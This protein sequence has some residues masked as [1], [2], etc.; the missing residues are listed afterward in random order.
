MNETAPDR[1]G[2]RAG[3][4][5]VPAAAQGDPPL[6]RRTLGAGREGGPGRD[7]RRPRDAR[8]RDR[9]RRAPRREAAGRHD[10]DGRPG[11]ATPLVRLHHVPHAGRQGVRGLLHAAAQVR[12]PDALQYAPVHQGQSAWQLYHGPGATTAV[13]FQPGADAAAARGAGVAGRGVPGGRRSSGHGGPLAREPR[14]GYIALRAFLL[15]DTPGPIALR[16]RLPRPNVVPFDFTTIAVEAPVIPR[17]WSAG[18]RCPRRS[19]R[20]THRPRRCLPR[21]A[22]PHAGR[23]RGRRAWWSC[24]ASRS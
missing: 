2:G 22:R 3:C 8:V 17:A 19:R 13:E 15:P 4:V 11:H 24:T 21:G 12:L 1:A 5:A 6:L 14:A 23:G 18:G 10:R 9:R 16:E 20:P 7:S